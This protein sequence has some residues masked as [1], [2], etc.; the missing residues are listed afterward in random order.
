M[1]LSVISKSMTTL[2]L[3]FGSK[4]SMQVQEAGSIQTIAIVTVNKY[5]YFFKY[6]HNI[7][8]ANYY[9]MIIL[10]YVRI[11]YMYVIQT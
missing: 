6:F 2:N 8:V 1:V 5:V 4:R 7:R 11:V 3:L 9:N 10:V